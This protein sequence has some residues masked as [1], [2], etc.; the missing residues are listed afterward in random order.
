VVHGQEDRSVAF[1]H[2]QRRGHVRA[3]HLVHPGSLDRP[4]SCSLG[5]CGLPGL[6]TASRLFSLMIRSVR[7]GDVLMPS[8]RS[9][10]HTFR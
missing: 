10:A 1:L 8:K 3:P 9:L 7:R 2:G 4:P 6:R 5:P